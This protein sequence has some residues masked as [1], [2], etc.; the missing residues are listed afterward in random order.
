[1][2]QILHKSLALKAFMLVA[3]MVSAITGAWAETVKIQY[4]GTET[5]NMTGNNDA[6]TLGLSPDEWSVVGEKGKNSNYPGL[7][8]AGDIRLYYALDGSNTITV[9]SLNEAT[10]ND[11]TMEFT[12]DSYSNVQVLV[13]GT[14]V[15]PTD[16]TYSINSSSFVI[17]NGNTSNVQVRIETITINYTPSSTPDPSLATTTKIDASGITNTD[18]YTGTNAGQL[19]AE[20]TDPEGSVIPNPELTWSSSNESVATIAADGTIT[21]VA[22]GTTTITVSYPGAEGQYKASNDTYNLTVIDSTPFEAEDGIFDF[23]KGNYGSGYEIGS[24]KVQSGT[25]TAGN[26]TMVTAGRNCWFKNNEGTTSLRLYK[27]N[28]EDAAG[29][30]TF[31]VPADKVITKIEFDGKDFSTNLS[32]STGSYVDGTW[33]GSANTVSFTAENATATVI[34]NVITVTY[35]VPGEVPVVVPVPTFNP[36]AGEV[37][38]GTTVEIIC[39]DEAEGIEYS[40]DQLTWNEVTEPFTIS[41]ATTIYARAY[42]I[43]GN[44]SSVVSASYTIKEE[45]PAYE[46]VT[47]PY[48][49]DFTKTQDK[50]VIEDKELSGLTYVWK[51][52]SK[53]GMKASAYN[54][55]NYVSES[56]LVSPLIDLTT[57]TGAADL[58][59]EHAT[60]LFNSIENA[61]A[62]ATVWVRTESGQWTKLEVNYPEALGWDF[63]QGGTVDLS[64][65]NGNKIQIGFKYVSSLESCGTWEIK[66]FTIQAG[67][68]VEKLEAGLS[69]SAANYTAT[70]GEENE[71]PVLANPN[72]LTVTYSSTN[73][74]VATVDEEGNITLLAAGQ[75]TIKATSEED[76]TYAAGS[77]SYLLVVKDQEV[78]GTD[79]YE[80]VTDAST[81]KNGDIIVIAFVGDITKDEVTTHYEMALSTTQNNNNRAAN[82]VTVNED[83]TITPG[84]S[85]QQITLEGEEGAWYF[86]VGN[87]YLYASSSSSNQ[88]KTEAE[89][90]DNA[91]AAISI[92]DNNAT[93]L[94]QG[95]NTHNDL[96]FNPNTQNGA[97]LFSCYTSTTSMSLPQI[98]RKVASE[99]P[100]VEGDVNND[101]KVTIA[102]VT[103]LVNIILGHPGEGVNTDAA[104]VNGDDKT[105]IADVTALVNLILKQ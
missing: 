89:A 7:N 39:P 3:M 101:G 69:Y 4:T 105:T 91:K 64:S 38:A 74:S 95:N 26:V 71:F 22:V 16:G 82:E 79:K 85:I 50:F 13:N 47:F 86:N 9:S 78:A 58:S 18:I 102:D 55:M 66:N 11:V 29:T 80:L 25:W 68:V 76:D 67:E 56:W 72:S 45:T 40:F 94:F 2:K 42:D 104:D 31:A 48:S 8:K 24:V 70:I 44:L 19:T 34:L 99:T 52:D 12:G 17:T 21:L 10:I 15:A 36:E 83:G 51:R 30:M 98:Y 35:G 92:S 96:R 90:D 88:M 5:T 63:V 77:A 100:A 23:G 62:E 37:V 84:S 14:V 27:P 49:V 73:E 57:N 6:A 20:V 61:I 60:N 75:T 33:T 93:I 59:F 43:D 53:Y 28:G 97:P 54:K 87:G 103:A 1:M 65:Y 81:L 41:E 46:T 32:A